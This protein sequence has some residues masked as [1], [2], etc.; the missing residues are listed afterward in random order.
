MNALVNVGLSYTY[1]EGGWFESSK[2]F[3]QFSE[4]KNSTPQ[5]LSRSRFAVKEHRP[6]GCFQYLGD[7]PFDIRDTQ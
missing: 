6:R 5:D 4:A 2:Y 7:L 3:I 1:K